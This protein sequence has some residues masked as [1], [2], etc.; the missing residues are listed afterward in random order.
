MHRELLKLRSKTQLE[1][2]LSIHFLLLFAFHLT[3]PSLT[4]SKGANTSIAVRYE[5]NAA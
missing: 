5:P 2:H 4:F 1:T 3:L